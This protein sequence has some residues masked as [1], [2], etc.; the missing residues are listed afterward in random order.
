MKKP[1]PDVQGQGPVL[2]F[3]LVDILCGDRHAIALVTDVK[4]AEAA[5][6]QLVLVERAHLVVIAIVILG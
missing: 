1:D 4:V 5:G 6:Q 2:A 3:L